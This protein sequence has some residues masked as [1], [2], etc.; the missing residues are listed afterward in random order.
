[1][2]SSISRYQRLP[3]H[4]VVSQWIRN[5]IDSGRLGIGAQ[6]PSEKEL[7]KT[8]NISRI[9]V[10][11]A[12]QT[13]ESE[14]LIYRKQGLGSFVA[15][16]R[17]RHGLVRLTDF[18]EDISSAG[19]EPSSKVLFYAQENAS[20]DVAKELGIE[21]RSVCVRL[22]RLRLGNGKPIAFDRTW[23]PLY[24]ARL[25]DGRDLERETIYQIL[26]REY[27]IPV[28]R[29]RYLIEAVNAD[30]ELAS[31]LEIKE[32]QA[33]LAIHRTSFTVSDQPIYFQKRFYRCDRVIYE[34]EL[35]RDPFKNFHIPSALPL[36][37]FSPLF[38]QPIKNG[39]S[40]S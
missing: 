27:K 21:E 25:L 15:D 22:D 26:Q 34:L 13:L 32:N 36:R 33:V 1:M 37:Q 5:E 38:V 16:F 9:T 20:K 2:Q 4:E 35:E 6:L 14:G 18:S 29:G 12:L 30:S 19:I 17:L 39:Q 31:Y 28:I 3:R 24:Y 10:R 23:L 7:Q 8:F 11:R 40:H